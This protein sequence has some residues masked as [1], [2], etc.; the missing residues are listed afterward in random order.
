MIQHPTDTATLTFTSSS[1]AAVYCMTVH[2]EYIYHDYE[3]I[4]SWRIIFHVLRVL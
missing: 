4:L 3:Y 1:P 2:S